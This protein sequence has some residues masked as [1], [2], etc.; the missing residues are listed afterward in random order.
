MAHL[1]R[2]NQYPN[3]LTFNRVLFYLGCMYEKLL[4]SAAFLDPLKGWIICVL[5]KPPTDQRVDQRV[6]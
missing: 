6:G 1:S 2:L 4:E 3:Y 5:E